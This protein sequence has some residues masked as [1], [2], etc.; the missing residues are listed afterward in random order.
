MVD[1]REVN[2]NWYRIKH[3]SSAMPESISGQMVL[4]QLAKLKCVALGKGKWR[5]KQLT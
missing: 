4:M 3:K 1:E 5:A 2:R